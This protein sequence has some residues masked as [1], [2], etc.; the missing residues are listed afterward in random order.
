MVGASQVKV[1]PSGTKP[2]T[3][4]IGV[5]EKEIPEHTFLTIF[6]IVGT[7]FTKN[8]SVKGVALLHAP[9]LGVTVYTAVC[10][11]LDVF[12]RFWV[13]APV[14]VP[15][16]PPV[17]DPEEYTGVPQVYTVFAGT[18]PLVILAGVTVIVPLQF[19]VLISLITGL[20][21]I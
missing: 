15:L 7:G 12:T 6:V 21:L 4:L 2:F 3:P 8:V 18:T 17:T 16:P 11:V 1:V 9:K 19:V 5:T 13:M 10:V 14:C 20:G